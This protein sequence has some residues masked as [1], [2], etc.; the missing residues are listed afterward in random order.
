MNDKLVLPSQIPWNEIKGKDLE[1]L[2]YWLFDSMGAKELEWRIGGKGCGTSDQGRDL[3]LSFYVSSPDGD[4]VQQKWWV[5]AKGR[6]GT[7]E[8]GEVRL[9]VIN[10]AGKTDVD[11]IVIAT[12]QTFSNPVRDW[13]KEWQRDHVRPK[14]KLW[15]R[16]E[17][18]NLCS[19][20]PIA[21][22]RLFAKAL[23]AQGKLEVAKTKLWD[24]A[25]FTDEPSLINL[26]HARKGLTIDSRSLMALVSS[27]IANGDI[28]A[29]SWAMFVNKEIVLQ[30]LGDGLLNFLYLVFRANETGVRQRP[31]IGAVAHLVLACTDRVGAVATSR[32]LSAVWESKG[33]TEKTRKM[34][35]TPVLDLLVTQVRDVCTS[36]CPRISTEPILLSEDEVTGYWRQIS[37]VTHEKVE[38]DN[39]ILVIESHNV[40]CKV[41][42]RLSKKKGCPLCNTDAPE[43]NILQTLKTIKSVADFRRSSR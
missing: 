17:L 18:E 37:S 14:V 26:W 22:I 27:E 16:T 11:V 33:Y 2:L 8:S 42:F 28:I 40:P 35:L 21:V 5:E 38:Q 7:V 4:L 9:A 20:H 41:G 13:V 12:N 15:E 32:V 24:Y 34:V 43:D 3:E 6:T 39:R 30:C 29:R 31:L 19:K 36:D 1:E 10:A 23:S 25:S